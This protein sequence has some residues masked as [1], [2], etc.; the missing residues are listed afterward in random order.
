[1]FDESFRRRLP[2]LVRWPV[3]QLA[4]RGVTPNQVTVV[5]CALGCAA[6]GLVAW[7]AP[8]SG[9]GLW[10][11]S[12]LLDGIDGILARETGRTSPFGGYLD[13]TLDML[14]Y[15]VMLGGFWLLHPEAGWAWPAILL[16]YLLVTTS[17]LALSSVLEQRQV[18]LRGAD[19]TFKFTPGLAEAGET[20][21]V[22]VLFALFPFWISP[23]AWIW[24]AM[25]AATVVQ[26]TV[27]AR[28]LLADG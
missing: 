15:S 13:I 21:A 9:V 25:C 18:A 11:V 5:A 14:A 16:G 22:Y 3:K 8:W 24:S 10:L 6:G 12:R 19:R 2:G 20:S 17:T 4:R 1:M 7:G 23:I 26:R 27:L 28:R